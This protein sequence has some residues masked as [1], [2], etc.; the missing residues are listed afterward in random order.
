[1][2]DYGG[3]TVKKSIFLLLVLFPLIASAE[4]V[5]WVD[6]NGVTHY[7]DSYANV[8]P[9]Y[10]DKIETNKPGKTADDQHRKP[11]AKASP[12]IEVSP[13]ILQGR[14]HDP[15][16]RMHA[17]MLDEGVKPQGKIDR[18][19][20]EVIIVT[21]WASEKIIKAIHPKEDLEFDFFSDKLIT[22]VTIEVSGCGVF[23]KEEGPW[24][25]NADIIISLDK[26]LFAIDGLV[27]NNDGTTANR[28]M[29]TAYDEAGTRIT[30]CY[31]GSKGQF[32]MLINQPVFQLRS[33]ADRLQLKKTGPWAD[34]AH[35]VM[36]VSKQDMFTII[37]VITDGSGN[38]VSG[39]RVGAN[40]EESGGKSAMSDEKGAYKLD[41]DKKIKQL[42]AYR[43]LT[44][45]EQKMDGPFDAD[46]TVNFTFAKGH[47]FSISG[48]VTDMSG[49][50]VY[51][52]FVYASND[53]GS[54]LKTAQTDRSGYYT[55]EVAKPA[56]TITAYI[57]P[58]QNMKT[59][60]R[61]PW[62]DDATVDIRL[63][64]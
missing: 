39:V 18:M 46:Q 63:E 22:H 59:A 61:G 56:A 60:I 41:V 38:P 5:K 13:F 14:I 36:A 31:T 64:R 11:A 40:F 43:E 55:L 27:K 48:R 62:Q 32:T 16:K 44:R 21:A 47:V 42:Y 37:G 26:S 50:P 1:L 15:N 24:R 29:V 33:S 58:A 49:N 35:V 4:F 53:S 30:Y 17:S 23:Y 20:R 2:I 34:N 57:F 54:R 10:L 52:A 7:A 45:E 8:P 25:E 51:N 19:G 12:A 9:Q 6:E 28:V 3:M